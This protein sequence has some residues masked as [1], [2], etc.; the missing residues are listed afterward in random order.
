MPYA[1]TLKIL[2]FKTDNRTEEKK[3][4]KD[5]DKLFVPPE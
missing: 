3:I 2:I 5:T 4:I 1:L